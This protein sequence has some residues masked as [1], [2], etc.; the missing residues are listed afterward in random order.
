[1]LVDIKNLSPVQ[2]FI[3]FN[4]FPLDYGI[5]SD[6]LLSH[7]YMW[8]P[9]QQFTSVHT[10]LRFKCLCSLLGFFFVVV[11]VGVR[12]RTEEAGLLF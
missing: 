10:D 2:S 12:I 4:C 9:G 8:P 3:F 11:V 7:S 5:S 1:M 6:L